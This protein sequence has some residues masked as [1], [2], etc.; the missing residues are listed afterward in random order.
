MEAEVET[1]A[2]AGRTF[3][4]HGGEP[5]LPELNNNHLFPSYAAASAAVPVPVLAKDPPGDVRNSPCSKHGGFFNHLIVVK[6]IEDPVA[7]T[8]KL[9]W[10]ITFLAAG[11][12]AIDPISS[13]IF[14]RTHLPVTVGNL[15]LTVGSSGPPIARQRLAY[16]S[17]SCKSCSCPFAAEPR[18][19]S[20]V[21]VFPVGE[22]WTSCS[23]YRVDDPVPGLQHS[24]REIDFDRYADRDAGF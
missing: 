5:N 17:Y 16:I 18:H 10:F 24:L 23:L 12:A 1:G 19:L 3:I 21:V 6:T 4:N 15:S 2:G 11:A 8:R 20:A 13:T 22:I 7:Y 14:Y 9:K